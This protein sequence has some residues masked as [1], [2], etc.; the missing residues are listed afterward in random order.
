MTRCDTG[1][2][3]ERPVSL[4]WR[5][6][7][8]S[9]LGLTAGRRETIVNT[10][11]KPQ[12]I[13][14]TASTTACSYSMLRIAQERWPWWVCT[15]L[16]PPMKSL[17]KASIQRHLWHFENTEDYGSVHFDNGIFCTHLYTALFALFFLSFVFLFSSYLFIYIYLLFSFCLLPSLACP[18]PSCKWHRAIPT[19]LKG[20]RPTPCMRIAKLDFTYFTFILGKRKRVDAFPLNQ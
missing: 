19:S 13:F 11:A 15:L 7:T 9:W 12:P 20:S 18:V 2:P 17:A 10:P 5:P 16:A 3:A 8:H 4:Q 14:W 6:P 1:K